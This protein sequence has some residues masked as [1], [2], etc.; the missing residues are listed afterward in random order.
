MLQTKRVIKVVEHEGKERPLTLAMACAKAGYSVADIEREVED[1]ADARMQYNRLITLLR[2]SL[3]EMALHGDKLRSE[4][5]QK[6]LTLQQRERSQ[7]KERDQQEVLSS[8]PVEIVLHTHRTK[9]SD[10]AIFDKSVED[11]GGEDDDKEQAETEEEDQ[12]DGSD[13]EE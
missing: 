10:V 3:E 13:S 4:A 11:D 7:S 1:N 5:A 6:I 8:R 9:N 12:A 2:A